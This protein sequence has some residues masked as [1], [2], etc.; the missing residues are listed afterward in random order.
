[1]SKEKFYYKAPFEKY[2]N[3][4]TND[5]YIDVPICVKVQRKLYIKG[6][7]YKLYKQRLWIIWF[8]FN[9]IQN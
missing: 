6:N 1:M 2:P 4:I 9:L 8:H 3:K 7:I 5:L